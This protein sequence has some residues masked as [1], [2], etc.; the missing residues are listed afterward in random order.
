[1][2]LDFVV[3]PIPRLG[4]REAVTA[5]HRRLANE[6][7][8]AQAQEVAVQLARD[9]GFAELIEA[10]PRWIDAVTVTK[11]YAGPNLPAWQVSCR[12]RKVIAPRILIS[13][14]VTSYL[15]ARDD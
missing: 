5:W 12:V 10:L 11:P 4:V 2:K 6:Q 15:D 13:G 8:A 3:R 1:M 14:R 7:S 9:I